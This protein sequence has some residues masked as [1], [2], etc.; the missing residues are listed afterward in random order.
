LK[1]VEPLPLLVGTRGGTSIL[2]FSIDIINHDHNKNTMKKA[3]S[4]ETTDDE[5]EIWSSEDEESEHVVEAEQEQ[6]ASA[7]VEAEKMLA[8]ADANV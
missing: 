6:E 8:I 2:I 3:T 1:I 5:E 4:N 7:K